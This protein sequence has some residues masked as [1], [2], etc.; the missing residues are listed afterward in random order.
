MSN[1]KQPNIEEKIAELERAVA[2]FDG[3]EFALEQALEK[4]EAAE[5]L[6]SAIQQDLVQF[7]NTIERVGEKAN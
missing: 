1:N 4:Y 7:K 3:D 2:W 5:K 6:A